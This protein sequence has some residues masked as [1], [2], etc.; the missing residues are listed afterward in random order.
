MSVGV[1]GVWKLSFPYP[2]YAL[3]LGLNGIAVKSHGGT[4]AIGYASAIKVAADL[5]EHGFMPD[6]QQAL[7]RFS[8]HQEAQVKASS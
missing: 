1:Q 4:D 5:V 3:F 7:M 8:T 6:V 2:F